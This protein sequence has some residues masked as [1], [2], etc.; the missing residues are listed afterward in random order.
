MNRLAHMLSVGRGIPADPV[1]AAKWHMIAKRLGLSDLRL[2]GFVESMPEDERQ[3]AVDRT[4][5]WRRH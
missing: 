4:A 1:E 2:D 5:T 3:K